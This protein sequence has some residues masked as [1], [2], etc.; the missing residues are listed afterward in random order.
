MPSAAIEL[1]HDADHIAFPAHYSEIYGPGDAAIAI[2]YFV[3]QLPMCMI[4]IRRIVSTGGVQKK[5][6][7]AT[8]GLMQ[9]LSVSRH[10]QHR[11]STKV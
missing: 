10:D 3:C 8:M 4:P 1:L 11:K 9:A 5:E 2:L 6:D 7:N